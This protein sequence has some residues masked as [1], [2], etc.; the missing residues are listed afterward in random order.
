MIT[1]DFYAQE[2]TPQKDAAKPSSLTWN[3]ASPLDR[4]AAQVLDIGVIVIPLFS[5]VVAPL[6]RQIVESQLVSDWQSVAAL[7]AHFAFIFLLVYL[8]AG[9]FCQLIFK[10]S[11]GKKVLGLK[12]INIWTGKP[13]SYWEY[14]IRSLFVFIQYLLMGF[15]FLFALTNR[16]YRGIHD[17]LSESIVVSETPSTPPINTW[18]IQSFSRILT[19][20]FLALLIPYTL[21]TLSLSAINFIDLKSLY[22]AYSKSKTPFCAEAENLEQAMALVASGHME[23]SCLKDYANLEFAD[24]AHPTALSYLARSFVHVEDPELSDRYLEKVCE[25]ESDSAACLLAQFIGSWSS[26]ETEQIESILQEGKKYNEP[27]FNLWALRYYQQSGHYKRSLEFAR[28]LIND[29]HIGI[30]V[31]TQVLKAK[32]FLDRP[33]ESDMDL[34]DMAEEFD[35]PV[36]LDTMAWSCLKKISNS[37]DQTGHPF[38]RAVME[39]SRTENLYQTRVLLSKIRLNECTGNEFYTRE[40]LTEGQPRVWSDF[41][42]ALSKEKRGDVKS[43]WSLYA[44]VVRSPS[45]PDYLKAEAVRR[46]TMNPELAEVRDLKALL[47]EIDTFEDRKESAQRVAEVFNKLELFEIARSISDEYDFDLKDHGKT[48]LPASVEESEQ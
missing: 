18:F 8:S 36:V 12:V 35:S 24:G 38:C 20:G 41:L 26:G 15:P 16:K 43:A 17:Q 44:D 39:A 14:L 6:K 22:E 28:D 42:Y 37:C 1:P 47:S 3:I 46:M 5:L 30:Y 34:V 31:R 40:Y 4:V 29:E 2:P 13:L 27:Y 10:N 11:F 25:S 45:T 33:R 23:T 21:Q 7:C 9:F 48:R 19:I 32:Y